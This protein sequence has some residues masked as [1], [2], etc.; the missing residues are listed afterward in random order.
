MPHYRPQVADPLD[1]VTFVHRIR[2]A[3][4]LAC[5]WEDEQTGGH[6]AD[7][8][9]HFTGAAHKWFTFTNGAHIDSLDPATFD[10]WYD[11][12]SLFVAHR[13]PMG[14]AGLVD[15]AAP[16]FYSAAMGLSGIRLPPDPI[17]RLPTYRAALRAY[18]RLPSVRILFDNG[19]GAAP[20]GT[21]TAGDP[22]PGFER[23]FARF[24]VPGTVARTWYLGAGGSLAAGPAGAAEVD[25]FTWNPGALPATD[26]TGTAGL[27]GNAADWRWNW[28]QPAPGAALSYVS[29]PLPQTTTVIGGGAVHLWIRAAVPSVD[30]QVT[31]SEVRPDGEETFVQNV[32]LRTDERRLAAGSTALEP[33]PDLRRSAV[34]PLPRGRFVQVTI[35]LYYEG[36]VYRAGSRIRLTVSAP[37]GSQPL[38]AFAR[39]RP[40]RPTD[41]AVELSR[42]TPSSLVLPVVPGVSVPTGL[43]PCPSLR[44]EPCRPYV[45]FVNRTG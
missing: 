42:A 35:P 36:H 1:P 32:W 38:W 24:P 43:P 39:T 9:Q 27:W 12:L 28:R 18:E 5:Q 14:N 17:Q 33:L 34:A 13:A 29:A 6:C 30:L 23:S 31:V 10:R 37:G 20:D 2:A 4:F 21:V 41:V 19:A 26:Y 11:F 8:A 45:P 44:N 15:L 7:L 22:Y 25:D 3:V 40:A 16:I